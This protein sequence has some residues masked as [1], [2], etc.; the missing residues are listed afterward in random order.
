MLNKSPCRPLSKCC[1]RQIISFL[2]G[3]VLMEMSEL[4]LGSDKAREND[5]S[6]V[7]GDSEISIQF[8][9]TF[10]DMI[11]NTTHTEFHT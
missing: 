2:I 11:S 1:N 9:E 5:K 6:M 4:V 7:N 3:S 10:P 8:Q